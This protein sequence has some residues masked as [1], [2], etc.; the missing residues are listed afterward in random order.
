MG[1]Q[2]LGLSA[3]WGRGANSRDAPVFQGE[4]DSYAVGAELGPQAAYQYAI[5]TAAKA[6]GQ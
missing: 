6:L 5:Q 3:T 4:P 2:A 1:A